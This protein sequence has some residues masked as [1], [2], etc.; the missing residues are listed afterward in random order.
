MN[1]NRRQT[2]HLLRSVALAALA[3][4]CADAGGL[5]T[6][7]PGRGRGRAA[8]LLPLTGASASLGQ[9]MA[10]AARLAQPADDPVLAL[11]IL[12]TGAGAQAAAQAALDGG[13][14][15][16][17]GPVFAAE[18]LA[19]M[20]VV[21]TRVPVLSLS[22]DA[23]LAGSGAC[24]FGLTQ[25]QSIASVLRYARGQ[26]VRRVAV[27]TAP[28]ALGRQSAAAVAASAAELGLTLTAQAAPGEALP[29]AVVLPV[30]GAALSDAARA[31]RGSGV[32][33][34]GTAQ[35]LGSDLLAD[36]ALVGAWY[37]APD[38]AGFA[39][40]AQ[41]FQAAGTGTA[42]VLA[43]LAYDA[44][45]VARAMAAAGGIGRQALTRAQGFP[46]AVGPVRCGA[47]GVCARDLA[48]HLVDRGRVRLVGRV[49]AA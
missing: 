4:A 28:D 21:G 10:R 48:I 18:T 5:G 11:S 13:A 34:L 27:V 33:L 26:G 30:G 29:D 16:V 46:G 32:Q 24:V 40:F 22:N 35:W 8:L 7:A 19:V 12:D 3:G 23:G 42:G 2:L 20:Q 38:P 17:L 31:Y 39:A 15:I 47:G 14:E 1:H 45:G 49:G 43:G 44:V 37:A 25:A 9:T 6:A 36:P 41:A